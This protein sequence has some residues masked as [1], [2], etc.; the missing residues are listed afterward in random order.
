MTQSESLWEVSARSET[1]YQR[2]ENQDRMSGIR[3]GSRQLYIVADGMGGHKAG[4]LA[5]ELT[6]RNLQEQLADMLS[7][8][9]DRRGIRAAFNRTNDV[10]YREAHSGNPDTEGMGSTAV[11]LLTM[12]RAV[13]VAHVGDSRAYLY[14]D[15]KLRCLTKDHSKVQKL[16][17][18]G[19]LTAAEARNHPQ[20]N[21][22]DRAIGNAP[23][24]DVDIQRA[25][26]LIEG[27]GFLLCSDGLCGYVDDPAIESAL[28]SRA[29]VQEVADMLVGLALDAGGEDN[30]TVQFIQF[31]RRRESPAGR[32]R[33]KT[34]FAEDSMQ[35]SSFFS[36][37][38]AAMLGAGLFAAGSTLYQ[39]AESE[40]WW[41]SWLDIG[42]RLQGETADVSEAPPDLT[43]A[44]NET[45]TL[46]DANE[47]AI[48]ALR[49]E[50]SELRQRVSDKP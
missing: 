17:D 3:I 39:R 7:A 50:L 46:A 19:V 11:M 6:V 25:L 36:L 29:T 44:L 22:I 47:K 15:G 32:A 4:A 10:V 9:P 23:D 41:R 18:D 40:G 20:A 2:D 30:V 27:D 8:M 42:S 24:V 14:R 34:R 49:A 45:R 5:A 35:R 12:G 43:K 37:T 48:A 13:Y 26:P 31:G 1:G 16:V 21:V 33:N 28:R 38:L